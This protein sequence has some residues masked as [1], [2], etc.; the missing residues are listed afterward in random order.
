MD[1]FLHL[2]AD[3]MALLKWLAGGVVVVAGAAWVVV[4]YFAERTRPPS[5]SA[6]HGSVAAGGRMSGNTITIVSPREQDGR[7]PE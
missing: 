1:A 6:A 7:A 4:K 3:N 2:L 5:V